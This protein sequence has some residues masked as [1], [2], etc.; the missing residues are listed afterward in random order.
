MVWGWVILAYIWFGTGKGWVVVVAAVVVMMWELQ[1]GWSG[2]VG[3]RRGVVV[4]RR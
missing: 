3:G 1:K 4:V 2:G